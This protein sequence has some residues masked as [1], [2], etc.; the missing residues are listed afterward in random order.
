MDLYNDFYLKQIIKKVNEGLITK[1]KD[2]SY[3]L[4]FFGS[5]IKRKEEFS[6][7]ELTKDVY[8]YLYKTNQMTLEEIPEEVKNRD[9]F[10]VTYPL[11]FLKENNKLFDRDFYKDLI[12]SNIQSS[13]SKNNCFTFMPLE[14]I[15]E[16]MCSLA[17]LKTLNNNIPNWF[18]TVVERKKEAITSDLWKLC[19]RLYAKKDENGNN[20]FLEVTPEEMKDDSFYLEMCRAN[21]YSET[22][23]DN[24]GRIM[25]D[26]P[27]EFITPKFV[28]TLFNETYGNL[29]RFN[30]KGFN[31]EITFKEGENNYSLTVWQYIIYRRGDLISLI[32][33]NDE[34]IEFFK[35]LY[36]ETDYEYKWFKK[37]LANYSSNKEEKQ[38]HL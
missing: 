29:N 38:Y 7:S 23:P 17:L 35:L 6:S 16:E 2:C 27:D 28:T 21:I 24:K 14:Y 20:R 15:D 36:D 33:L 8:S 12:E 37:A 31:T 10:I 1:G 26:V 9:F 25:E 30:E 18:Y 11:E 19:A 5:R 32:P 22:E 13:L 34:R 3:N 4:P